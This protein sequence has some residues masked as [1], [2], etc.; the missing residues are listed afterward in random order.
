MKKSILLPL[1]LTLGAFADTPSFTLLNKGLY[2]PLSRELQFPFSSAQVTNLEIVVSKCYVNNLNAYRLDS[3]DMKSRMATVV[4]KRIELTPPFA[5]KANRLLKL[6]DL[7]ELGQPGIYHLQ[8]NTGVRVKRYSWS[9]WWTEL[10]DDC[11]FALTDLGLAATVAPSKDG[12]KAVVLVHSLA[13]GAP[14]AGVKVTV[15][16]KANQIAGEGSTDPQGVAEIP[17]KPSYRPQED[18]IYGVLATAGDDVAYLQLD[19]QSAVRTRDDAGQLELEDARAFLF[20]ERDIC[21]PGESFDTGLF[22]RQSPQ[23]GMK[24]LGNAPVELELRDPE[25]NSVDQRRIRTDRWGFAAATWAVPAAART[26]SWTVRARLAGRQLGTFSVTVSAY[27]PDRFRVELKGDR[28]AGGL[29]FRGAAAYYFG[30]SVREGGWKLSAAARLAPPAAHWA[31]WTVGTDE[32]PE[33]L[34]WAEK[35]QVSDGAF[36]ARYPQE[37]LTRLRQSKS[38]VLLD[39][40]ASVTPIG[41]RTVTAR[42]TLRLDAAERYVGVREAAAHVRGRRAFEFAFLPAEKGACVA[43]NGT[44]DVKLVR[45][46]WKCHAVERNGGYRMEWREERTELPQLARRTGAGVVSYGDEELASGSY[47]LVATCGALETRLDFWQWAGEVSARSASPAELQLKAD[48]DRVK[49]GE[50]VGLSFVSSVAG[51]AYVAV[52]ERG[53]EQTRVL[54]VRPGENRFSIAVR[55]DAAG[56]HTYA[57]VTLIGR[58]RPNARRLSGLARVRVDH[59]A[60]RYPVELTLPDVARP[61]ETVGVTVRADGAGAVRLMAVD[62]GVLALTG[63]AAPDAFRHFHDNDFGCPFGLYDVYSQVYPDLKILP[64][65]QIGGGALG[66]AMKRKNVRTRRCAAT[67]RS[68]FSPGIRRFGSGPTATAGR[69]GTSARMTASGAFPFGWTRFPSRSAPL[70]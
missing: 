35:G 33:G 26:G 12:P 37:L 66:A 70:P 54:T 7:R 36:G 43:T 19:W 50:S 67:I 55:P 57:A 62:E 65:G 63:Y 3:D 13:N 42:E 32:I 11:L 4:K 5:E 61:G 28:A 14:C 59:A 18:D 45:R 53:I 25:G 40:E 68:T 41:A 9:S 51:L 23:G 30:E 56:S 69:S 58:D 21:R 31:D 29:S 24:A 6:S 52:G 34:G 8:V 1:L 27:V 44:I 15:L 17:F 16:T 39:V 38:P 22:L 2:Y 64:N 46:E 10:E 49:P 47:T 20:A 60:T 48:R